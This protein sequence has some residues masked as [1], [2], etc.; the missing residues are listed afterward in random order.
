MTRNISS[1][2]IKP[3][4]LF[5]KNTRGM[6][7]TVSRDIAVVV[8]QELFGTHEVP[9]SINTIDLQR[10]LDYAYDARI[11]AWRIKVK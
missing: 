8:A 11:F 10:K 3:N 7:F 2:K 5:T 1:I 9:S 6:I 4:R